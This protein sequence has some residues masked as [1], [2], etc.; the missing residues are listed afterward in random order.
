MSESI[1]MSPEDVR[2]KYRLLKS[3][4]AKTSLALTILER[5]CTHPL[6]T[7]K[8]GGSSGNYDPSDNHYWIDW[9]CP[10][11]GRRWTTP[12][13]S[14]EKRKYPQAIDI[15]HLDLASRR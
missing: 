13:D 6:L 8:Y 7:M 15:T 2:K 10:D 1:K 11:C 5:D 3:L 14:N 9:A 4:Q 12:Q